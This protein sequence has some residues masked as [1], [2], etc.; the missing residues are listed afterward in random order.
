MS[1]PVGAM[2]HLRRQVMDTRVVLPAIVAVVFGLTGANPADAQA[3]PDRLIKI[4]VPYPP[5][6]PADVAA[7][8]VVQPLSSGLGQSVIIENQ[9]GAGGRTGAKAVA[10]AGP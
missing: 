9:P 7:R 4:V 2:D 8:L 5:G 1:Y 10:P 6:G 3:F